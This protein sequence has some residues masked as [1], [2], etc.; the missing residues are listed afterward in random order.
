MSSP[1][2]RARVLMTIVMVAVMAA[3]AI[4]GTISAFTSTASDAPNT[5]SAG[6]VTLDDND[7]A[8]AMFSMAG[9]KPGL[10]DTACIK[11]T[12][13]GTLPNLLRV[14]GTTTGTGLDAYLNV[15]VTRG[16]GATSFDD[17][18][19]FTPDA[20]DWRGLGAGVVF[21]G[22]LQAFPD[23]WAGGV[24]DP[25]AAVPEAWTTGETHTYR[26]AVTLADTDAAQGLTAAQTFT[27]EARNTTLYSQVV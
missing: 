24:V 25:R 20:S 27:W 18:T 9:L 15:V 13:N 14:Y 23:D 11:V 22:T 10:S 21:S 8:T 1:G 26:F 17:C 19:G 3:I 16:T 2:L 5:F 7:S 4:P 12:S 6:T